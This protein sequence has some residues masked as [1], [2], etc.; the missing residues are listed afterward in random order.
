MP[1]VETS[2]Q[3][4]SFINQV[5]LNQLSAISKLPSMVGIGEAGAEFKSSS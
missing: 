3:V 5:V 4:N 1:P 2:T